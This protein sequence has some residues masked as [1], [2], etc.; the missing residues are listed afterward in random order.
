M[1]TKRNAALPE[2]LEAGGYRIVRRIASGGFS[3]VYLAH[4]ADGQPVALKEYLPA[5]LVT[6][7]VGELVPKVSGENLA[8]YRNGLKCFFEEGR[9]LSKVIHPNV[10]R[11]LN[12]FRA[13]DTVYMV[14]AYEGGRSLQEV[15]VHH[16]SR[17]GTEV[18][19][20]RHIRRIFTQVTNGLREVHANR[21]LHLD[22]KPANIY[23][24]RDGTPMLLDF[25]AA[26]QALAQNAPKLFPMYTPGFAAPELYR[27]NQQLGPWTDIYGLGASMYACMLG[28]PAQPADQRGVIDKVDAALSNVSGDYSRELLDLVRWC[29][30]IDPLERPQ[31]VF[32]LQR[33]LIGTQVVTPARRVAASTRWL[34]ALLSRWRRHKPTAETTALWP[35]QKGEA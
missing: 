21:L 9:A 13:H 29:M 16:R 22:L 32:S 26:R 15:I 1:S 20:E 12:F 7:S 2:G 18:L 24:K 4:D 34:D 27:K 35:T 23:L 10:V 28:A 19:A 31:S 25:G 5:S 8:T 11:V 17:P 3:I 30:K 6:R 14:M 33:A